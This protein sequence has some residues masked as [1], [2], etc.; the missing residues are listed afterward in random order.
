[1]MTMMKVSV[2]VRFCFYNR[3]SCVGKM[4]CGC[5]SSHNSS[6]SNYGSSRLERIEKKDTIEKT[7]KG[8]HSKCHCVRHRRT[9]HVQAPGNS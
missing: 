5:W 2:C 8:L 9:P 6:A 4:L 1:M 7:P 3:N